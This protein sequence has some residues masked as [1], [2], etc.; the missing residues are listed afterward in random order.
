MSLLTRATKALKKNEKEPKKKEV[1]KVKDVEA[2][3][4]SADAPASTA[5]P[6]A[7]V[8]GLTALLTEKGM[9][10]QEKNVAVF[11]VK[12]KASKGQIRQAIFE[13]FGVRPI[14]IRTAHFMGKRRRRG[15]QS[16]MTPAWKKAFVKV[17]DVTKL[18]SEDA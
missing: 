4:T 10:A 18:A 5:K 9:Y 17:E 13:K 1:T 14:A 2:E 6:I 11:R 12:P 15:A 7:D 16:G 8:I 3:K